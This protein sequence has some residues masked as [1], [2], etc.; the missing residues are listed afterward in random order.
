MDSIEVMQWCTEL[1]Q[2]FVDLPPKLYKASAPEVIEKIAKLN[3]GLAKV[4][5]AIVKMLSD[6]IE[7]LPARIEEGIRNASKTIATEVKTS[8]HAAVAKPT[9]ADIV[10]RNSNVLILKPMEQGEMNGHRKN[11]RELAE[12]TSAMKAA[13]GPANNQ[14]KLGGIRAAA[15]NGAV[16]EFASKE[17]LDAARAALEQCS[18]VTKYLVSLPR[19]PQIVIKFVPQEAGEEDVL[20]AIGSCIGVTRDNCKVVKMLGKDDR[21]TRPY[22]LEV[23][24][25]SKAALLTKKFIM[26]G[27]FSRCIV[28]EKSNQCYACYG[29]GHIAAHCKLQRCGKCAST[30]HSIKDCPAQIFKCCNCAAKK[31]NMTNVPE[32][33][34]FQTWLCPVARSAFN[35][36][37]GQ[38]NIAKNLTRALVN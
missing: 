12:L 29:F 4:Q 33:S 8:L 26:V 9:M 30:E 10:K 38:V 36:P 21:A 2:F 22:L 35:S 25:D 11:N 14:V 24:E 6:K 34:A 31:V 37:S 28:E 15:N 13:L 1:G 3:E 18:A 20:D 27:G 5:M 16:C 17:D 7:Q 19:K 32:H 23:D